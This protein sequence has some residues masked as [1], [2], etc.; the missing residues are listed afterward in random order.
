MPFMTEF[1]AFRAGQHHEGL[2]FCDSAGNAPATRRR[3]ALRRPLTIVYGRPDGAYGCP[4][5]STVVRLEIEG[6][7]Q[8]IVRDNNVDQA[9]RALK[10]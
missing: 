2:N 5:G 1:A 9:L 10:K 3:P 6:L 4:G 7:M 8:I